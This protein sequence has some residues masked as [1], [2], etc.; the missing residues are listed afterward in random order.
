MRQLLL[1][2]LLLTAGALA[3]A[4]PDALPQPL[5]LQQAVT[6]ALTESRLALSAALD[7]GLQQQ[8][9]LLAESE[10]SPKLVISGE[11]DRS[12]AEVRTNAATVS[13]VSSLK[14]ASGAQLSLSLNQSADRV[15]G[16]RSSRALVTALRLVQPLLKGN[17]SVGMLGLEGARLS[18]AIGQLQYDRLLSDI[19]VNVVLAYFD[20]SQASGQV[21][22]A[23]QAL[24]RVREIQSV[25]TALYRAGRLAQQDLLQFEVDI[26][27]GELNLAQEQN[28]S[29]QAKRNLLR[30]L[31][32]VGVQ[33]QAQSLR[34][35][36]VPAP[37]AAATLNESELLAVAFA[38]REDIKVSELALKLA[39]FGLRRADNDLL[40]QL[41][42]V[43]TSEKTTSSPAT[44]V[45]TRTKPNYSAGLVFNIPIPDTASQVARNRARADVQKAQW[46]LQDL[47]LD[48]RNQ[49][50]S[51]VRDLRF[52]QSQLL[53]AARS[54]DL[55][56]KRLAN[57]L[58]KLKAGR[59][60][61]FQLSAAQDSLRQAQVAWGAA[62]LAV[63]RAQLQLH[64]VTAQVHA[65]WNPNNQEQL[66]R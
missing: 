50:S 16:A 33:A 32:P 5:T 26:A 45:A 1:S 11:T 34:L 46:A 7:L 6:L 63:P 40:P 3:R 38:S 62:Q 60:S 21:E 9:L 39:N 20:A 43:A 24:E 35:A 49:V 48:V 28:T 64:R 54:L 8:D 13:G 47:R 25:N 59:T 19:I 22:L 15:S 44:D 53:L 65:Q 36:D 57:E 12:V 41:D 42:L 37:T 30:L 55:S 23:Q 14:L 66:S 27:Q 51:S 4:A 10:F 29:E 56:Q 18:T 61:T 58:E 52:A 31:G 2:L 17:A